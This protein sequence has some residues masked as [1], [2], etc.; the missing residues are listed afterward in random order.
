MKRVNTIIEGLYSN[1]IQ[2]AANKVKR[3]I[4]PEDLNKYAKS[5]EKKYKKDSTD[6]NESY[7]KSTREDYLKEFYSACMRSLKPQGF[8]VDG[9]R[10]SLQN[11]RKSFEYTHVNFSSACPKKWISEVEDWLINN[12]KKNEKEW[13]SSRY[14]FSEVNGKKYVSH[15]W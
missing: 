5:I 9:L 4:S 10:I 8:D 14:T 12:I 3:P 6:W 15:N 7:S 1:K 13:V 2:E 11:F